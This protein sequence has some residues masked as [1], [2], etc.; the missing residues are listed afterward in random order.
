MDKKKLS[1]GKKPEISSFYVMK[2]DDEVVWEGRDL[3]HQMTRVKKQNP[4][5]KISIMW[6]TEKEFLIV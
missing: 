1:L 5:S 4:K 3:K 6:K 2:I